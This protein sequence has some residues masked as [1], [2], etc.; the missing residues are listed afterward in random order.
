MT[1]TCLTCNQTHGRRE[2]FRN[3]EV[4]I[5]SVEHLKQTFFGFG[6]GLLPGCHLWTCLMFPVPSSTSDTD[7]EMKTA[8]LSL[9]LQSFFADEEVEVRCESPGCSGTHGKLRRRILRLP[10]ILVIHLKRF[11]PNYQKARYEKITSPVEIHSSFGIR[12][13]HFSA[14]TPGRVGPPNV[15][16]LSL[17]RGFL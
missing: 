15:N 9:L 2:P 1:L 8:P 4:D 3:L 6:S 12:S 7:V 16:D 11:K 13:S 5:L 17:F 10:R 14:V